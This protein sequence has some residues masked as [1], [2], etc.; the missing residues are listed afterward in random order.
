MSE[1]KVGKTKRLK[2]LF[3]DSNAPAKKAGVL[4]EVRKREHYENQA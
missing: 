4:S 3:V 1:I 2:V